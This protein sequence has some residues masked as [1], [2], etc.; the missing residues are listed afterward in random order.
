ME[1]QI[2]NEI[3]SQVIKTGWFTPLECIL[4]SALVGLFYIF[5]RFVKGTFAKVL[6]AI[7]NNTKVTEELIQ[8]IR[9]K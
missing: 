3:A 5:F 9:R 7:T 6:I 1:P 8:E 2:V 4:M